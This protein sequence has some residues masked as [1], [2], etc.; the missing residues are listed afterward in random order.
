MDIH[1]CSLYKQYCIIFPVL[2]GSGKWDLA[3]ISCKIN[4]CLKF[5]T[6]D[7]CIR[8]NLL[9]ELQLGHQ[10]ANSTANSYR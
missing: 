6:S 1:S 9:F 2:N 10:P 7:V 4:S 3:Y 5:L 8:M